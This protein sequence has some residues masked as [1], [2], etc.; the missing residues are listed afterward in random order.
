MENNKI[1]KILFFPAL[2]IYYETILKIS[3]Y[4]TVLNVGYI[5]MFLFSLPI[6]ILLYLFASGFKEKVN[7]IIFMVIIFIL[8]FFYGAQLLYFKI[9]STFASLYFL[10]GAKKATQFLNVLLSEIKSN[11]LMVLLILLPLVLLLFYH[12]KIKLLKTS[13]KNILI[14]LL[15]AVLM[16]FSIA[17]TVMNFD[18]GML[19]SSYL[20]S[21]TFLVVD[22]IDRFGLLTTARLDLK[23][24]LKNSNV[25]AS[26]TKPIKASDVEENAKIKEVELNEEVK[27]NEKV[28]ENV[29]TIKFHLMDIPFNEMAELEQNN[30]I[31]EMHEYFKSVEPTKENKY[32]GMYKGKNLIMITAESF[33]P[34]A[35]NKELTPT[36]YKMQEEG[37]KF[38]DFY[39][40]LWGV[41]TTDGEYVACTSLLPKAG[42][43]SFYKSANNYMPFSM[44]NQLK[45]LGYETNAYHNHYYDY[46][47][48]N[49]THPNMGYTYKGLGNGLDVTETWPES[50]LE[51][52]ELTVPE[53]IDSQPFHTYYMTVSGHLQY[54]FPGNYI[55][56]KN[57]SLV[58]KLPYSDSV[59]AYLA[60]NIEFDRAM[61]KLINSL[62][63][64]G[65]A[66]DTLIAISP[67]H[68]PYGLTE[69]EISE[70]AGHEIES[71][72]EIYK[73]IF[74]LWSKGMD[75]VEINKTCSSLDILPTISN[76]MGVEYDSRLM[77]G[78]DI[79]SDSEP[80]V[81][82]L[83][84]SWVTDKA[85]FNA[86]TGEIITR[87]GQS[88]DE[89]YIENVEVKV[90]N[91][92][93]YAT[94]ILDNNY[95]DIV[96][97]K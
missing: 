58:D 2:I 14:G 96:L 45:E 22:S 24:I 6:G 90:K 28:K 27:E 38:T 50:D 49:E 86:E 80:L 9:F 46:Y 67:D 25:L 55:A 33:S 62:E 31:K 5:F 39:T 26:E 63:E 57:K 59:K 95:Y 76:L 89:S 15:I 74:I 78:T 17:V 3:T 40:P 82:F 36:L 10:I 1:A 41:S 79:L 85:F 87:D 52:M 91:K 60:C 66:E 29:E 18:S 88:V 81:M 35:V 84:R 42:I 12:K 7:K 21:E 65:I 92:F 69:S 20:Y 8:T 54:N 23:N 97:G 93:K 70:L 94:R 47:Y 32:T 71:C 68:Y 77:M 30:E 11:I 19:S 53:Y 72:F 83:D 73:G 43:W 4:D 56:H 13:K 48:R 16:Q 61:E 34:Y 64:A 75:S 37:F 51:M 44:G